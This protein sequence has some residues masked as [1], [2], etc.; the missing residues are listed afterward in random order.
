MKKSH[1]QN[2]GT[3][4]EGKKSIPKVRE[5]EGNE[6]SVPKIWER[7]G[8]EKNP[9]PKFGNGK[10]MKKIHS[11]NSGRESEASI[12]GNDREREGNEKLQ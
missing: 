1:S 2:S 7:E 9:F 12:L 5:Q 10:G 8:N 11:R 3:G 6:K 4:R